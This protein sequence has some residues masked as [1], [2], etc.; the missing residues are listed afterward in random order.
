MQIYSL[1]YEQGAALTDWAQL[2]G[3]CIIDTSHTSDTRYAIRRF[4]EIMRESLSAV[5]YIV[6]EAEDDFPD[7]HAHEILDDLVDALTNTIQIQSKGLLT[8]VN[9]EGAYCVVS[10]E[11]E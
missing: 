11:Q 7:D 2:N 10:Q 3:S 1:L 8:L 4:V 5:P 9:N 6:L